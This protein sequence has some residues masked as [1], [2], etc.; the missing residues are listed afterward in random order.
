MSLKRTTRTIANGDD[1]YDHYI[2]DV[3]DGPPGRYLLWMSTTH[4]NLFVM[5]GDGVSAVSIENT[6]SDTFNY[7]NYEITVEGADIY[8]I[9]YT[10]S[11]RG[12]VLKVCFSEDAGFWHLIPVDGNGLPLTNVEPHT[13]SPP[14]PTNQLLGRQDL[15]I[16]GGNRTIDLSN[17]FTDPNNDDLTYTAVSSVENVATVSVAGSTLTI[18]PI[19]TGVAR[20]GRHGLTTAVSW[21]R[22]R[23]A[24]Q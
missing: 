7:L 3:N 11:K 24:S 16:T 13:N 6:M 14:Q 17:Y 1:D 8:K 9:Y 18:T 4:D 23:R 10:T 5:A 22:R 12:A 2:E 20:R 21:H 15:E 19:N